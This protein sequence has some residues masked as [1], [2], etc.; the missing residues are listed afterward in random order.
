MKKV[1]KIS[2]III[3]SLLIL[4]ITGCDNLDNKPTLSELSKINDQIIEYFQSDNI[5]YDN[6]SFNYVDDRA[7]VVVVGLLDNS[8]EQQEKFKELVVDSEY[9]VFIKADLRYDEVNDD[10]NITLN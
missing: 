5:Q 3:C 2:V 9:L 1:L 4:G 7:K 8:K 10:N 6:Y